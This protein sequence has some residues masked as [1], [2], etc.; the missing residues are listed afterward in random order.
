M[1]DLDT[2][3]IQISTQHLLGAANR[4]T[5]RSE[6]DQWVITVDGREWHRDG[7]GWFAYDGTRDERG[8]SV[9]V[10]TWTDEDM[11]AF[12]IEHLEHYGMTAADINRMFS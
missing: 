7:S 4:V 12:A 11:R 5:P 3:A 1:N 6:R 8:L 9:R 10:A 2:A